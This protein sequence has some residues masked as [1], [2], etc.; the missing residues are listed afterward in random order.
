MCP[1]EQIANGFANEMAINQPQSTM[2]THI[3]LAIEWAK[4][5][6]YLMGI[7]LVNSAENA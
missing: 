1:M 5:G 4:N 2:I 7:F 6:R 3:G